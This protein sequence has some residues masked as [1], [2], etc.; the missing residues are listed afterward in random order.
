VRFD[1]FK[2]EN[3]IRMSEIGILSRISGPKKE[4]ATVE[5][6]LI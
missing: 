3:G 6:C 2:E 5:T 1:N 4:E